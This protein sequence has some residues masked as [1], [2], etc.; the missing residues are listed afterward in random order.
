MEAL[1]RLAALGIHLPL[2]HACNTG[3]FL[4]LPQAHFDMVRL[5]ILPLGVY[6]SKV[7]RRIA[8]LK[9]ILSV[10]AR[11]AALQHIQP[12]DHVGYS[13]RYTADSPRTIAVLPVGY[14]DGL[15]R[16]RN[17]GHVL[18][19]GHKAPIV[20]GNAMDATMVDVTH[21]PEVRQWDETV[22]LGRQGEE[23]ITAHDLAALGGTVSYDIMTKLGIRLQRV[24]E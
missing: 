15:P 9:P 19:H 5:G 8:G 13:M 20:G 17:A 3:G 18:I 11:I 16:V 14:G 21:I 23:E 7:C 1:H 2:R 12:G 10:K 6:P 4:D 22:L 24:Y